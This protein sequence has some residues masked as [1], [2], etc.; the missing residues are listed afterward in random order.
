MLNNEKQFS[1]QCRRVL[2]TGATGYVGRNLT[3][4][5][6]EQNFFVRILLRDPSRTEAPA[7]AEV[8]QGVL[9]DPSSLSG[10]EEGIDCVVHC[11]AL[12]GKWNTNKARMYQVNVSGSLHLLDRFAGRPF[13]QFIHLSAGGVTGPAAQRRI[14]E[15]HHCRPSTTY[16]QT[17]Y[18]AEQKVL[19]L[20]GQKN[21][22]ALVLRPAFVYGPGDPH[23]LPL[24]KAIQQGRFV[25]IGNGQSVISPVYIDDLIK[26]ILLALDKGRPGEIYIIGGRQPVTK[27]KLINTIADALGVKRPRI[28]IPRRPAWIC[29]MVLEHLGRVFRF[30]PILTRSRVSMMADNFG[31]SIQKAMAELGYKPEIDLAVGIA[32][33]IKN[34]AHKGWL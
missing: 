4:T 34:Y 30:E 2:V 20:S 15:T 25:L 7:G 28:K 5:L 32:R 8:F 12:L 21:I 3:R 18:L 24:F 14:D 1:A 10:I 31:Y 16:E 11:A 17:K 33:T 19:G 29:A 27:Q 22:P 23:K 26:A 13:K 6:V 9:L